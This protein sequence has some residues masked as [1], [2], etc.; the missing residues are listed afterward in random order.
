MFETKY[1]KQQCRMVKGR[2]VPLKRLFYA[3]A[4]GLKNIKY[5]NRAVITSSLG[6]NN[7]IRLCI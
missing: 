2:M 7:S 4:L 1:S 3:V 6:V 5:S